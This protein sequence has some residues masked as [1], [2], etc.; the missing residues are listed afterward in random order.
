MNWTILIGV[1]LLWCSIEDIKAMNVPLIGIGLFTVVG[2]LLSIFYPMF[3]MIEILGGV[4]IGLV[5]L[6]ISWISKDAIGK[7][8]GLLIAT[9]G[10]YLGFWGN[11]V[12]LSYGLLL[13]GITS[14]IL[15]I[16][17]QLRRKQKVP[18]VPFLLCVYIGMVI[19]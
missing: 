17:K 1:L 2:I 8:D 5:L 12:L 11:M 18:F 4:L 19:F 3:S 14:G 16:A 9:C 10:L 6:F 13:A 15:L 7:G